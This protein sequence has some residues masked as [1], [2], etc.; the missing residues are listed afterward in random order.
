[1]GVLNVE[2]LADD[3][4]VSMMLLIFCKPGTCLAEVY[5]SASSSLSLSGAS[6]FEEPLGFLGLSLIPFEHKDE[7]EVL[8]RLKEDDCKGK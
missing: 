1:M 6:P 5:S 7:S 2:E 8:W 4:V 3:A